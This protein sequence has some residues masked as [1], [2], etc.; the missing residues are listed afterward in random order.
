VVAYEA[1]PQ[2]EGI[3]TV[4]GVGPFHRAL[5]KILADH[6]GTANSFGTHH[7]KYTHNSTFGSFSTVFVM[8]PIYLFLSAFLIFLS[9]FFS[10]WVLAGAFLIA[11]LL[12][13]PLLM[14]FAPYLSRL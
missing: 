11:F 14:T 5:E 8:L 12:S 9:A 4:F 3:L 1:V 6:A 13:S 7:I 10:F 2:I